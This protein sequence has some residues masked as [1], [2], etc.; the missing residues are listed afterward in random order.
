MN[1]NLENAFTIQPTLMHKGPQLHYLSMEFQLY[2]PSVTASNSAE[3]M[4]KR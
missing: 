2:P 4:L 1:N 3:L